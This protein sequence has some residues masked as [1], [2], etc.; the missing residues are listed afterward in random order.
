M[1]K[2]VLNRFSIVVLSL[3]IIAFMPVGY[4]HYKNE[5]PRAYLCDTNFNGR[6]DLTCIPCP[7]GYT[8]TRH[9]YFIDDCPLPVKRL[10]GN[11]PRLYISKDYIISNY[12]YLH[13]LL[14]NYNSNNRNKTLSDVDV[15]KMTKE[16]DDFNFKVKAKLAN[17]LKPIEHE[18]V[19]D[20]VCYAIAICIVL[21]LLALTVL[22]IL[23][24]LTK[25]VIHGRTKESSI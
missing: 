22:Y 9:A 25:Y 11:S 5:V 23:R 8:D 7:D 4:Y 1:R 16:L 24:S 10:A 15:N 20:S 13:I 6:S 2:G 17:D 14:N 18:Y 12:N 3:S 19:L 21:P